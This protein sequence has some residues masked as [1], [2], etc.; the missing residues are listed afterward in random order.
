M[1]KILAYLTQFLEFVLG[2]RAEIAAL[3]QQIA[4]RDVIIANLEAAIEAE[5]ADD[6]S[7]EQA[8]TDAKAAQAVAES[9]LAALYAE[10]ETTEAE[11]AK[12]AAEITADS[13]IPINV[14]PDTGEV[15]KE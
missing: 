3:K 11:A 8:V 10:I 14:D 7:L 1:K 13:T 4:D 2:K 12:V 15:T 9:S 5:N 6:A